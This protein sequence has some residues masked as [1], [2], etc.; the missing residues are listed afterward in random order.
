MHCVL[1]ICSDSDK[2]L[3]TELVLLGSINVAT[4]ANCNHTLKANKENV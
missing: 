4:E 3:A 1:I 2:N